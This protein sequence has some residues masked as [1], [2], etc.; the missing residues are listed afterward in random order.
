MR[1]ARAC[2]APPPVLPPV[3]HILQGGNPFAPNGNKS[4]VR[5]AAERCQVLGLEK[6]DTKGKDK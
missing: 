5:V 1:A 4:A 3:P 2:R 6:N